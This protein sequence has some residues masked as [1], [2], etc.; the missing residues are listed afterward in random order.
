MS[1]IE[2]TRTA[3]TTRLRLTVRG[4]R[5]LSVLAA[6]PVVAAVGYAALSGGGAVASSEGPGTLVSFDTVTVMPGDSLWS[7][8]S[9]VADGADV[10]EVVG[11]ITRLNALSTSL[12]E[13]GQTLAI[14]TAYTA[15][16]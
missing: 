7:I 6:L 9:E 16:K 15:G 2:L 3:P 14:P 5:I 12:I 10:R 11:D 1:T 13:V 4:R 8:A